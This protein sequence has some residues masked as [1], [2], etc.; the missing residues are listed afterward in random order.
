MIKLSNLKAPLGYTE[1][2]LRRMACEQ[3]HI[4]DKDIEKLMKQFG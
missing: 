3:L 1:K 2:T 4:Q